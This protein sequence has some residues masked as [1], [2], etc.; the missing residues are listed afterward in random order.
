M[1][2]AGEEG[3]GRVV[4]EKRPL[5]HQDTLDVFAEGR[6]LTQQLHT[7]FSQNRLKQEQLNQFSAT[8]FVKEFMTNK[9]SGL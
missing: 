6:I 5:V 9:M 2:E 7:R 1:Q 8:V 3:V 4:V